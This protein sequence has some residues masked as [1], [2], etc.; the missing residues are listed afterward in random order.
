[1]WYASHR[2][3]A[4]YLIDFAT[5]KAPESWKL[6]PEQLLDVMQRTQSFSEESLQFMKRMLEQSGVGPSTAWPPGIVQMLSG[7][8]QDDS[9]E[10]SRKEA[11]VN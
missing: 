4:V 8:K 10:A 2:S 6:S 11:E 1:M 9:V 7:E 3:G 5:F